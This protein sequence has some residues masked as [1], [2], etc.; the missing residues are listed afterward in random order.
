MVIYLF[1]SGKKQP[2]PDIAKW[3]F[4]DVKVDASV[5]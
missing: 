1:A 4:V 2:I 5:L 3:V